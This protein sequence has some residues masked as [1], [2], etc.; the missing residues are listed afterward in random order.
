MFWQG[1]R[2]CCT[3]ASF[4]PVRVYNLSQIICP[5]LKIGETGWC[6]PAQKVGKSCSVQARP[7]AFTRRIMG[8]CKTLSWGLPLPKL[9]LTCQTQG[10]CDSASGATTSAASTD[11]LQLTFPV[12][13]PMRTVWLQCSP[14]AIQREICCI[15]P[16][17]LMAGLAWSPR[18]ER[19]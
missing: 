10:V 11:Q 18:L 3:S 15:F 1:S 8:S 2:S 9:P 13:V 5:N 6:L 4:I 17:A 12:L 16:M 14:E 19:A 7:H